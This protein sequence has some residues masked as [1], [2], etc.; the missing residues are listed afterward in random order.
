MGRHYTSAEALCPFYR[1]EE[2][3]AIYCEG[4]T[5]GSTIKLYYEK[6]VPTLKKYKAKHCRKDWQTCPIAAMLWAKKE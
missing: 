3:R 6:D 5:D 2:P 4:L 1:Y